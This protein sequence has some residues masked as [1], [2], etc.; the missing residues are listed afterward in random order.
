MNTTPFE[1]SRGYLGRIGTYLSEM[2]PIPRRLVGAIMIFAAVSL[3]LHR[4]NA[5]PLD[6]ANTWSTL[7]VWSVFA[8]LLILRIMDEFKDRDI[9]EQLFRERPLP[10]GRVEESDLT[11]TLTI[12]CVL[13]IAA[14]IPA[15]PALWSGLAV[16]G[17]AFL[18]FRF[19]FF[20]DQMR[21]SLP[22]ALVTHNPIIPLMVLHLVVI[23]SVQ[24]ARPLTDLNWPAVA[25]LVL[26][27]WAPGFAWEI[28]RKIRSPEEEDAYVTYSQLL[29]RRGAVALAAVAQ[30]ASLL[31]G[32]CFVAASFLSVWLLV[33]QAVGFV[34]TGWAYLRFLRSPSPRTSKL[35]PHA[36]N[37]MTF[38][39][40]ALIVGG[41][42]P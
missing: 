22:L 11:F 42:V 35:G 10:S 39:L 38:V 37:Y 24:A 8:L 33:I 29:G 4:L 1:I 28:A 13:F 3:S 25:L 5:V 31:I 34:V 36:E 17:Y 27:I 12:V 23:F 19:F 6:L 30:A 18:M 26:M 40:V 21:R 2:Y 20:P 9:D 32:A 14:H 16:L 15:G 41:L 7:G